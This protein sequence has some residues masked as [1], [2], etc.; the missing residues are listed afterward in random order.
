MATRVCNGVKFFEHFQK[1]TSQ[2]TFL[3]NL[4]LI[5]PAVLEEEM[6]KE[7]YDVQQTLDRPKSSPW[8]CSA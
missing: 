5:G 2:G 1:K 4:V 7:I 6:F 8:A 3:P